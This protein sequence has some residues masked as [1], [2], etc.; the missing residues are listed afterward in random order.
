MGLELGT[1]L[2]LRDAADGSPLALSRVREICASWAENQEVA[3]EDAVH[4]PGR[5]GGTV[6]AETKTLA[7][8]QARWT[9]THAV[10]DDDDSIEWR[11]EIVAIFDHD[12]TTFSAR[13]RRESI[14]HRL[15]PLTG[16]PMAPAV[17]RCVVQEEGVDCFDGPLRIDSR[18]RDLEVGDVDGFVETMLLADDRRLPIIAVAKS[19]SGGRVDVQRLTRELTGFAH[20]WLV[21]GAALPTIH[22]HLGSLSLDR[23]AI[24]LWWAGLEPDDDTR[25]HPHRVGPFSN[26]AA[27]AHEIRGL[28]FAAS[29]DR[30]REPTR[31]VEFTRAESRERDEKGRAAVA[32]LHEELR[33]LRESGA[34]EA[35]N[36]PDLEVISSDI[37][38]LEEELER[39]REARDEATEQW[40]DAEAER[41]R[42]A[43][44]NF[45][46]RSQR[47][48]LIEQLQTAQQAGDGEALTSDQLIERDIRVAWEKTLTPHDRG[49][50]PLV[51]FTVRDG[52]T[53]SIQD[54]RADREKVVEVAMQVACGLAAELE[55]RQPHQLRTSSAGNAPARVRA[56]DGAIAWRCYLQHKT[57]AARRLHYWVKSDGSIEFACVVTHDDMTIPE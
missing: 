56:A 10:P 30:W 9:L 36:A 38:E 48:T 18:F 14:D 52:F 22:D 16:S 37:Q 12:R 7:D 39:V 47:Q 11:T 24:R 26:P 54:A 53:A 19:G 57:P 44:E 5:N 15:R 13:L 50:R 8:G 34:G 51:G 6:T 42:L 2:I 3:T 43:Q 17:I 49:E 27:V 20:V 45:G 41:E 55:S 29:R 25:L 33:A 46:L 35:L 1:R 28:V 23:Q 40:A 4:G 21:D 32:R 31:I